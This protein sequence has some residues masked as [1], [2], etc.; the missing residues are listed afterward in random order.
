MA[1]EFPPL[2]NRQLRPPKTP[3][4][5][6]AALRPTER[7]PRAS[8][9]TPPRS[10]HG[11]TDSLDGAESRRPVSRR[12]TTD[13][14]KQA[15][16]G[17]VSEEAQSPTTE[18]AL[19]TTGLPAVTGPPTRGHW[20][21][22]AHASICDAPVCQKSFGLFERRHHCRHCG[23]VF[24]GK[25]SVW[26]I[27]LDQDGNYHP[28]GGLYRGCGHCWGMYAKWKEDRIE[29][30]ARGESLAPGTPAKA[31]AKGTG[32]GADDKRGSVAAS[33]TREWNWSTF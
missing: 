15:S 27:P 8:P 25:H 31:V 14:R 11:S 29:A 32:K 7:P 23:N 4:Y 20:K 1:I 2:A 18:Q 16:L 13:S 24:C 30:A 33:L 26:Q 17:Q 21:P 19:L 28:N 22:D 10:V 12:S 5:V 3:M 9:I 6:P